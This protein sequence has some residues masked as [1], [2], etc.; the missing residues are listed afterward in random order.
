MKI[1]TY[2]ADKLTE[3]RL[4]ELSERTTMSQSLIIR[5]AVG[6]YYKNNK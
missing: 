2:V 4:R 3:E 1:K 5:L 6:E